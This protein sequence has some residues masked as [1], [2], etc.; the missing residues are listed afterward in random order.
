MFSLR[1]IDLAITSWLA[2]YFAGFTAR[3]LVALNTS[4]NQLFIASEARQTMLQCGIKEKQKGAWLEYMAGQGKIDSQVELCMQWQQASSD[5][6][7]VTCQDV[8]YPSLLLHIN[9]PPLLLFVAGNAD[10]LT[11]PMLA[12]VGSRNPT[13]AGAEIAYSFARDLAARN[14]PVVSGMAIGV[15]GACHNGALASGL[16]VAVLGTG[17]DVIYPKRHKTLAAKIRD[18]GALVS[19]FMLGTAPLARH[20]PRRNRIISGIALGVVVVEAARQSGSLIT[21]RLALDSNREVFAIPGSIHNPL[22]KGC[23]QLIR[24]G[25]TLV[26]S[27][28]DVLEHVSIGLEQL[29]TEHQK[30]DAPFTT[31]NDVA[32]LSQDGRIVLSSV[33]FEPTPIDVVTE[34]TRLNVSLVNSL[35]IELELEGHVQAVVGG[36]IR[37]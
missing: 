19:E 32:N 31:N 11:R 12:M 26:E 18:N 22:T 14:I 15:D 24:E 21:A 4:I 9:S 28:A 34:R 5:H 1:H 3:Q 17:V 27:V 7:L 29:S 20:F 13:V 35:L 16:T 25:A 37:G 8:R 33:G 2:L 30:S 36:Y 6:H 23:H 10:V